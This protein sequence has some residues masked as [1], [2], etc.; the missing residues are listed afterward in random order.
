MTRTTACSPCAIRALNT[1]TNTY[2]PSSSPSAGK[3]ASQ[4]DQLSR[5]T[6]FV[7]TGDNAS[8][9]GGTTTVKDPKGNVTVETYQYGLL[10]QGTRGFGT[11]Q[12]VTWIYRYDP[13]TLGQTSAADPNSHTTSMSYDSRGNLLT[14][15]DALN[16]T[17][18]YTYN[19]LNEPLT[20]TDAKN[21]T[22]TNTYDLE[23]NLQT[24]PPC[25]DCT[26]PATS[27]RR[28]STQTRF[29]L[30]TSRR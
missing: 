19:A 22:T 26:P 6:T 23:G 24:L 25:P 11:P 27:S 12:A 4:K 28:T 30:G 3:V 13:A 9:A 20:T 5:T 10:V 1:V 14:K 2:S 29:I 15:T 16:R 18:S 17:T 8:A 7:Y 21:V